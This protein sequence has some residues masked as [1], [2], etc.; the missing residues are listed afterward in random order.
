M[1]STLGFFIIDI[2][3]ESIK[4]AGV[5]SG[6]NRTIG[7]LMC[8]FLPY[9][10]ITRYNVATTLP[11]SSKA[12]R[13]MVLKYVVDGKLKSNLQVTEAVSYLKKLPQGSTVLILILFNS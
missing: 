4:E 3:A 1:I 12:Y 11:E 9:A 10:F 7:N 8:V 6:C 13:P 5:L 2:V